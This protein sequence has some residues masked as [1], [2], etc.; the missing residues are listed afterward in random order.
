MYGAIKKKKRYLNGL[1]QRLHFIVE[2][3]LTESPPM[4]LSMV[5]LTSEAASPRYVSSFAERL[6]LVCFTVIRVTPSYF[7]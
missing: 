4:N 2:R 3:K 5:V 7:L 6:V 1:K